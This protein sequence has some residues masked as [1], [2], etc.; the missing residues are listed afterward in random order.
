LLLKEAIMRARVVFL[1]ALLFFASTA[2]AQIVN[3][4]PGEYEVTLDIQTGVADA[5]RGPIKRVECVTPEDVKDAANMFGG[6]NV[7]NCQISDV[8]STGNKTRFNTTCV[9][10][11]H[12]M[13]G[14]SEMTFGSD[15]VEQTS[16]MK[17]DRGRVVTAKLFAKRLG[18]C[19]K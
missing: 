9:E 4:R 18:E 11:G 8:K 3:I 13:T 12:K 7:E 10:D 14:S 19:R 16:T 1:F 15:T 5:P 17:D 2:G 6:G